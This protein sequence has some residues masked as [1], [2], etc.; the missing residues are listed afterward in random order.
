MKKIHDAPKSWPR[1]EWSEQARRI[2]EE[3]YLWKDA[4]GR[5]QETVEG[6]FY[7]VAMTVA[8]SEAEF[9]ARKSDIRWAARQFYEMMIERRFIP[10]T[11][12]LA[13][14]GKN[15]NL[16]YSACFVLPIPDSMRGIFN[17]IRNMALIHKSGGGTGFAF[18]RLRPK[19]SVVGATGGLASGPISFM[20]IFDAATGE[21]KQGGMR[22]GANMAV[23]RVD[24]PDILD[25]IEVKLAGGITNFNLSVGITDE[26][27]RALQRGGK[28]WLRAQP[29]WPDGKG[30]RYRGGEKIRAISARK[31]F[32]KIIKAAWRIG[33]PGLV[34]LDRMNH[35]SA[36]PVPSM[37]PIESTNPCLLGST[38]IVTDQG[39]IAIKE[40][41]EKQAASQVLVAD[42]SWK[43]IT[44]FWPRGKKPIWRLTTKK[45]YRLE[46]TPDHLIFTQRGW[47]ELSQLQPEKD[48]VQ[49]QKQPG[50][51]GEAKLPVK[52]IPFHFPATWSKQ[53]GMVL[54]WL[55]G[56]GWL[57]DDRREAR[58]GF[59]FAAGDQESRQL[60]TKF[61]NRWYGK[62]IKAVRRPN[63]VWHLS[64]HSPQLVAFFQSLGIKAVKAEKKRVPQSLF[65]AP[66]EAV[67]GF[68]QG[69]FSADGTVG[70][71]EAKGSKYARLTSKSRALLQD[72]QLLLLNL[73]IK[74][75]IYNRSRPPR[76]NF[77][78][79][80]RAGEEKVY[81]SDGVLYELDI[82]RSSLALFLQQIGF[83]GSRHN[84]KLAALAEHGTYQEDDGDWVLKVE[85]TGR[86]EEVYDISVPGPNHFYANG[87][88][89]HNCGEQPLYPNEAC[90]LGSL[91]LGLM[92]ENSEVD[93]QKLRQ[94]VRLAVRFLDDVID[95]NPFPLKQIT[96]TVRAN[97]RIGLGVMGWADMLFK[98]GIPYDSRRGVQLAAKVMRT[99]NETGHQAS[100]ELAKTR[101]P[102]PNFKKS[103]YRQGLPLRNATV[104]TIAPT[105]S[106]S[107]IAN[108]SSGIEPLFALAYVHKSGDRVLGF[109]NPV[110]EAIVS[111]YPQAE[112]I[113]DWAKENGTLGEAP[114]FVPAKLKRLFKTA[115]EV[116]WHWHIR[117]QAA[118]QK[119]TDN[120][121][122]KTINM[123]NEATV[124][125][126]GSAYKYAYSTGCNGITVFRDGCRSE[127]VLSAGLK[128]KEEKKEAA[129]AAAP[130]PALKPRPAVVQGAT[131]RVE[132]P[133]G[134]AFVTVN[135]HGQVDHPLEVFIAV[136]R[137]GSDIAADA[138]ALGRL[139]SLC[140]RISSPGLDERQVTELII[141]QLE[142][143]GGGTAVGFGKKRVRSLADGVAKVLKW[144][145][146]SQKQAS[147]EVENI[148]QQTSLLAEGGEKGVLAGEKNRED[149]W[150]SEET[151]GAR[152]V[153]KDREELLAKTRRKG[154]LDICPVCGN[155]SLVYE[156]GCARCLVC[157]YSKC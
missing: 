128:Q 100:Q 138:E 52:E 69:L 74:S 145:L 61:M 121:V 152:K 49:L 111:Q 27:W 68:L 86:Q 21:I 59:T 156:E 153:A 85:D 93:W 147:P 53:L 45:G 9:G 11:P 19:G 125:D 135:H 97:R 98:L 1:G 83:L 139:I 57:R 60:I 107:I 44:G 84:Q 136:G 151:D 72:V 116:D 96:E 38:R 33:D 66:Q 36:N 157:G 99:I 70:W 64:Y 8:G 28:Y 65:A 134:T 16:Q 127:Q 23:L 144:H 79:R 119:Y 150:K 12:T 90:N 35:G 3:R 63:H 50:S 126:V 73:G 56:D 81:Q 137:A 114:D 15:N 48:R 20:K 105:G 94:T 4:R 155:A 55:V 34:F 67:V 92:V 91:N 131:Y 46:A 77:R 113:L 5:T 18:S 117:M 37:G 110:F 148:S 118:F 6:M 130:Q 13:N 124:T 51:G 29:G 7:R 154:H 30:G 133:V 103:I 2:L 102:F 95:I 75:T 109:V 104:T 89:V 88:L 80:N 17:A 43:H 26:F 106:I 42:G 24:H 122:S 76:S 10:N 47:V 62:E 149:A 123:P 14:A 129:Q 132:T 146:N 78:Y 108:A 40:L 115:H 71:Q 87:I 82:S 142:G 54:G 143:I 101:G 25:F 120:A 39:L 58:V 32:E 41:V 31:V 140:L 112:K 22:R 141:D